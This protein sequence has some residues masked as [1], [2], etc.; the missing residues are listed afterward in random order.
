MTGAINFKKF[1]LYQPSSLFEPLLIRI[2]GITAT[3]DSNISSCYITK[4]DRSF[5]DAEESN[6]LDKQITNHKER[7]KLELDFMSE[8]VFRINLDSCNPIISRKGNVLTF[9][10]NIYIQRNPRIVTE[11]DLNIPVHCDFRLDHDVK[12]QRKIE[13]LAKQLLL[14]NNDDYQLEHSFYNVTKVYEVYSSNLPNKGENELKLVKNGPMKT[15]LK[16]LLE[17]DF[18]M[19]AFQIEEDGDIYLECLLSITKSNGNPTINEVSVSSKFHVLPPW[20]QSEM[21]QHYL[22]TGALKMK[23]DAGNNTDKNSK[24]SPKICL[25][26]KNFTLLLTGANLGI[27]VF[28]MISYFVAMHCTNNKRYVEGT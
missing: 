15:P 4:A 14:S 1:A 11:A 3:T 17:L 22:K 13:P 27:I 23:D 6:T 2:N 19:L 26:W 12:N 5:E 25:E 20:I 21:R 9:S 7:N 10:N 24:I 18:D 8:F 28:W 16:K